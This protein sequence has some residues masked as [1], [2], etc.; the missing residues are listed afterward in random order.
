MLSHEHR[1]L[2]SASLDL[3]GFA[4][5][6]LNWLLR[7]KSAQDTE[8]PAPHPAE[9]E[10]RVGKL[11]IA[12]SVDVAPSLD[13]TLRVAFRSP[14]LSPLKA[15]DHLESFLRPRLPLIPNTE[16]Q[17]EMDDRNWIHFT[18]KYTADSLKA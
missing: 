18:R 8:E 14:G 1:T 4:L 7:A 6:P 13:T 12:A 17:V 11:R 9:Y 15:A 16:W 3:L 10:R 5:D 2:E